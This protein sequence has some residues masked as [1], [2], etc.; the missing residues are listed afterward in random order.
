SRLSHAAS[1][2]PYVSVRIALL[3][4]H[5]Q[6]QGAGGEDILGV[7][8]RLSEIPHCD[9]TTATVLKVLPAVFPWMRFLHDAAAREFAAART[10]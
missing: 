5:D 10:V 9:E 8:E 2:G 4:G 6:N 3:S 1:L 7:Y